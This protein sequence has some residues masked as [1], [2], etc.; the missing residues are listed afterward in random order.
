M[1]GERGW[2]NVSSNTAMTQTFVPYTSEYL[3]LRYHVRRSSVN[4]GLN[5]NVQIPFH[6]MRQLADGHRLCVHTFTYTLDSNLPLYYVSTGYMLGNPTAC[7][8]EKT[9]T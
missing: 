3:Y 9:A 4:E 2:P 5:H 6:G 1:L 8:C 7:L